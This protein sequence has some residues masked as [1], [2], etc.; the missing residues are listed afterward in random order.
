MCKFSLALP[1]GPSGLSSRSVWVRPK[2]G[3]GC[4]CASLT[5]SVQPERV[6]KLEVEL[7]VPAQEFLLNGSY[8]AEPFQSL[9][10]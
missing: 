10:I 5:G 4:F 1:V 8:N 9:S 6:G 7:P 2:Y 3:K